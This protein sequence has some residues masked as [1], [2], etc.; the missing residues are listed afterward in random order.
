MVSKIG[1]V[2]IVGVATSE[3][4]VVSESG[5]SNIETS[6]GGERRDVGCSSC[7]ISCPDINLRY[8]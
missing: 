2:S 1:G 4:G 8:P 6:E 5:S 3:M 7:I